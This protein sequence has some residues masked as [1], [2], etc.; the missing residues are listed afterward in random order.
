M[1]D[2][3]APRFGLVLP[4]FGRDPQV[5]EMLEV[6]RLA[7][8]AGFDSLWVR[9]RLAA[10]A[11]HGL[12]LEA[13][14][15]TFF[16][17]LLSLAA[18]A[19][20]TERITLGTAVLL[21]NR[22]PLRLVQEVGTLWSLAEG[23]LAIGLGLGVGSKNFESLGLNYRSRIELFE[24]TVKAL[25]GATSPDTGVEIDPAPGEGLMLYYGG[26]SRAA[27]RRAFEHTDGWIAG[28]LPRDT[29]RARM[30]LAGRFSVD[31]GRRLDIASMPI[32]LVDAGD[33]R[34]L[35]TARE[36]VGILARSAEGASDWI[37]PPSGRFETVEDLAGLLI[38]GSPP[39]C[40]EQAMAM[41]ESGVDH[42]IFDLRL[43]FDDCRRQVTMLAEEVLPALR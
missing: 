14:G 3:A 41:V 9:D 39:E 31:T 33:G 11:P 38:T 2:R 34:H 22:H 40:A 1:P 26:V 17:P 18:V 19:A 36:A 21:P 6:A 42:L 35:D 4:H 8:N 7:D 27:V 13:G 20:V 23:R 24:E 12:L 43:V 25:R 30:E 28:R 32:T 15:T 10:G 37:K 16:E 29:F 5:S